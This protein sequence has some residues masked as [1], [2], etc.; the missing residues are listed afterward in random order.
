MRQVFLD[1]ETTGLAAD[2]GDRIVEIGC[3]EMINRRFSER[4]FHRYLNPQRASHPDAQRV[5]GLSE[6]FLADKPMFADIVPELLEFLAGA[7]IVIHN[8]AFDTGFVDAELARTGRPPLARHVLR[9]VDSLT[10]AR[11]LFPGKHNSLDALC[12]RLEVDNSARTLHGALLDAELLAE[13][14]LRMTRGQ[15]AFVIDSDSSTP[16]ALP[17]A[18]ADLSRFD[19]LRIAPD[20]EESAAH[21]AVLAD[22]D[23]AC[24]GKA[25]WRAMA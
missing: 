8:A 5:H 2:Q 15:G 24:K 23:Q 11:E 9:I 19:L 4:R 18:A 21:A 12:R 16:G 10:M 6:A 13:V 17:A 22:I 3:V 14:Y 7:E 20:A 25:V 1:T